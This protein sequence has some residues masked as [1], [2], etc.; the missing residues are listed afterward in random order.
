V[1][2]RL[3]DNAV[4]RGTGVRMKNTSLL[5]GLLF[6]SEGQRMTLTHAVK[7][8]RRYRN[9]V[10]RPPIIGARA[11][12]AGLRIPAADIE[13]IIT[14]RIRL[15]LSEPASVFNILEAQI[16]EPMLQ[17]KLIARAA[18]LA[19]QF[20]Q[21]LPLRM[22]IMLLALVHRVDADA[23]KEIIHFRPRR[24]AALLDDCLTATGREPVDDEPTLPLSHPV[25][26]RRAGKE[27]RMVIDHTDPFA[28]PAKPDRALIG[29][30][31]QP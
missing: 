30:P 1:Q 15:L 20:G 12:A 25:H 14:N 10:S 27:V 9:Y 21:M 17:Q 3:A 28:R 26:L 16:S 22:R 29:S 31:R 23:D 11:N 2:A 24:L 5:T 4:E 8:G 6:D 13:Q 19:C 18:E 7:K